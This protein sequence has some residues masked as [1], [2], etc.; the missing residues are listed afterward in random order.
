[1][2]QLRLQAGVFVQVVFQPITLLLDRQTPTRATEQRLKLPFQQVLKEHRQP[3][4]QLA[5]SLHALDL[6]D[7]LDISLRQAAVAQRRRLPLSL[8]LPPRG[9]WN[10]AY[11]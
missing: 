3:V 10:M 1:M 11:G 6:F 7:I 8:A 9:W 4:H 5:L 2:R